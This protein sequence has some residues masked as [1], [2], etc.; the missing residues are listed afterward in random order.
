MST[1]AVDQQNHPL[2]NLTYRRHPLNAW[3]RD[4]A[5]THQLVHATAAFV[6]DPDIT[7]RDRI[8][9]ALHE[10]RKLGYVNYDEPERLVDWSMPK[11]ICSLHDSKWCAFGPLRSSRLY[12]RLA[13]IA[14]RAHISAV[15]CEQLA[16]DLYG[17]TAI[18]NRCEAL[19]E[20]YV[21]TCGQSDARGAGLPGGR[22]F[23][24]PRLHDPGR[25]IRAAL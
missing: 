23:N 10:L 25:R 1:Q 12:R 22:I 2:T 11:M 13:H 3:N 14:Q 9:V 8:A 16:L 18:F 20:P 4:Q 24:S 17:F 15:E 19:Q 21:F 6:S 7:D 5:G